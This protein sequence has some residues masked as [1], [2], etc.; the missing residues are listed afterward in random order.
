MTPAPAVLP[1]I[2]DRRRMDRRQSEAERA[3]AVKEAVLQC[4]RYLRCRNQFTAATML[5]DHVNKLVEQ[6]QS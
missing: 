4:A 2:A 5:L 3:L 1:L 6:V